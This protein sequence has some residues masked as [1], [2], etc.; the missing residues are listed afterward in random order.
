MYRYYCLRIGVTATE[1]YKT[2]S[3]ETEYIDIALFVYCYS[4]GYESDIDMVFFHR[5]CICGFCCDVDDRFGVWV[6]SKNV[7]HG[8]RQICCDM[9]GTDD[10]DDDCYDDESSHRA[11]NASSCCLW[12]KIFLL[13]V[14]M[15]C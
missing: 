13:N 15:S 8:D 7:V 11:Y 2:F 5:I 14:V 6:Y 9:N 10:G 12:C 3:H 1:N 4:Y